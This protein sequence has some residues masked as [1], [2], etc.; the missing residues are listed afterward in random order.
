MAEMLVYADAE[1][2]KALRA[3]NLILFF[4]ALNR[5]ADLSGEQGYSR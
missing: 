2:W 4:V 5:N 3:R 1:A